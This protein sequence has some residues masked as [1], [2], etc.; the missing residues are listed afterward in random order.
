MN[1]ST[2]SKVQN[3][4]DHGK[5]DRGNPSVHAVPQE[6]CSSKETPARNPGELHV[7]DEGGFESF[8]R[9]AGI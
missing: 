4:A 8:V 9:G 5:E 1:P 2:R 6:L 7:S 3:E